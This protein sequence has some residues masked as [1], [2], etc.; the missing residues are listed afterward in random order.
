MMMTP[1]STMILPSCNDPFEQTHVDRVACFFRGIIIVAAASKFG[2][3]R[4]SRPTGIRAARWSATWW[5]Q[6]SRGC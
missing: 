3:G 5:K 4:R 6:P 1:F 2:A